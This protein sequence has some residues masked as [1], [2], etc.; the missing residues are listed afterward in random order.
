MWVYSIEDFNK[1]VTF[2]YYSIMECSKQFNISRTTISKYLD[3]KT[4]YLNKYIF[5]STPLNYA[6]L[7]SLVIPL[8]TWEIVTG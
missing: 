5:S 7:D 8:K 3:T 4:V 2:N 6:L 1:I